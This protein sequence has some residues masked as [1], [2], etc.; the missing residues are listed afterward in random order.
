MGSC[1]TRYLTG[2]FVAVFLAGAAA[3]PAVAETCRPDLVELKGPSGQA[4]FRVEVAD[5]DATR[6]RGLMWR[7]HLDAGAGMLFI[8]ERPGRGQFWMRNT[9]IPLDMIFADPTGTIRHIHSNAQP[10]DETVIDGGDNVLAVLEINGGYARRMGIKPGDVMRHPAF[11]QETA[12][13]SCD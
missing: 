3:A 4:R 11:S 9:L 10:K 13:W 8:Y 2:A 1:V 5:S 6:A 7:E 12:A